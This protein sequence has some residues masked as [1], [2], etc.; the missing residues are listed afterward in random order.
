M[1]PQLYARMTGPERRFAERFFG[2]FRTH[3]AEPS[4]RNGATYPEVAKR[5]YTRAVVALMFLSTPLAWAGAIAISLA[6]GRA[7]VLAPGFGLLAVVACWMAWGF[8]RATI[9]GGYYRSQD[10]EAR[11]PGGQ[12]TP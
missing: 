2:Q 10:A 12:P 4:P 5:A 7:S 3:M 11:R 6:N 9:V 1:S 8:W